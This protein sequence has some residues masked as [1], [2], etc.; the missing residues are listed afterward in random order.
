[1]QFCHFR[2]FGSE[3]CFSSFFANYDD[4]T[5]FFHKHKKPQI[6]AKRM[7][8]IKNSIELSKLQ[9]RP[10]EAFEK[11]NRGYGLSSNLKKWI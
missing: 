7:K 1:M 10:R 2:L 9:H 6:L 11:Y 4:H 3:S 5:C 8:N